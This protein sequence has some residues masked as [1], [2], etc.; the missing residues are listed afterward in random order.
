MH[1]QRQIELDCKEILEEMQEHLCNQ[2]FLLRNHKGPQGTHE[3][4]M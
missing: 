3:A 2:S 1:I 4:Q